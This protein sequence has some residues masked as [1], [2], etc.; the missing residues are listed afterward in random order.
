MTVQPTAQYGHTDGI[1]CPMVSFGLAAGRAAAGFIES[2]DSES[3]A[4]IVEEAADTLSNFLLE[5]TVDSICRVLRKL[6]IYKNC[7]N[8]QKNL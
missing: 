8:T 7:P 3:P 5:T 6:K 1:F 2:D 4:R